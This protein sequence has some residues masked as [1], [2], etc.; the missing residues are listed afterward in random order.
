MSPTS[1]SS[2]VDRRR[3]SE[4][5]L[6]P[7]VVIVAVIIMCLILLGLYFYYKYLGTL[8]TVYD[9]NWTYLCSTVCAVCDIN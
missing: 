4:V 5:E 1:A 3:S 6:T 2:S 7:L 8:Q 9:I